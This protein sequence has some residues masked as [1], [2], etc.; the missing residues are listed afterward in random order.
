M[1]GF[2]AVK[3]GY[4]DT[5]LPDVTREEEISIGAVLKENGV[6]PTPLRIRQYKKEYILKLA[7]K[8]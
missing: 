6:T 7:V 5:W 4:F 2:K 8:E 1:T 3:Q